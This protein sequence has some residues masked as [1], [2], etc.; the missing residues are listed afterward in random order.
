[1]RES[2]SWHRAVMLAILLLVITSVR[3]QTVSPNT[4]PSP[5]P[6]PTPQASPTPSLEKEFFKNILR[7]QRAFILSPFHLT[8]SDTKFLLPLGAAT[9][10]LIA[11]DRSTE[12]ELI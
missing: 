10:A 12:A 11:T 1:M 4:Q 5:Q 3:A 9:I 2:H 8:G 7:D 6:S